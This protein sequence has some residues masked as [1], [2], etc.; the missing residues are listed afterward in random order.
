MIKIVKRETDEWRNE[1]KVGNN[2]I[3]IKM[4]EME[5]LWYQKI[6]KNN[7]YLTA[8]YFVEYSNGNIAQGEPHD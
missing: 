4:E 1:D 3:G 7:R 5:P 2:F 8:F 6:L